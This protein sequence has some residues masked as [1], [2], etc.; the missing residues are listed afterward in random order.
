MVE[1]SE[2]AEDVEGDIRQAQKLLEND[3][4]VLTKQE[5]VDNNCSIADVADFADY[6]VDDAAAT[7]AETTDVAVVDDTC[8]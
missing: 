1:D 3:R 4:H 8:F 7:A 5:M 2:P 6:V